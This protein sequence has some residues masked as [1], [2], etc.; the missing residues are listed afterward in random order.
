MTQE[1]F[2]NEILNALDGALDPQLRATGEYSLLYQLSVDQRLELEVDPKRPTRGQSAFNVDICVYEEAAD[3]LQVPRVAV[4]VKTRVHTNHVITHSSRA[5]RHKQVYPYLRYGMFVTTEATIPNRVFQHNEH[6]DFVL[7]VQELEEEER[8]RT[9]ARLIGQEVG[10]S[11][12]LEQIATG[13]A[14]THLYRR[15]VDLT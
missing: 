11:R 10:A 1:E 13:A 9:V 7:A 12:R 14:D 3:G 2:V 6:L 8:H 5:R 4:E 15:G